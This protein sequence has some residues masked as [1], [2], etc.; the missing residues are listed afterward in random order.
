[1][2][3]IRA[4]RDNPDGFDQA[5]MRRDKSFAGTAAG[6]VALDDERRRIIGELQTLQETRNAR[7]KEI[8]K[9]KAA[10]DE[11]RAQELMAEVSALKERAPALEAD[12]R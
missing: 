7:S 6:L 9:A 3:D 2:H 8:G 4:I 11:A 5:L 1:M 10:K 12:Q